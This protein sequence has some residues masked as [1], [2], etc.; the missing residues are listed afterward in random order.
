[1]GVCFSFAFA[2]VDAS[3]NVDKV[4]IE[5]EVLYKKNCSICH[6][7]KGK[8]G[9]GG[10]ANLSKSTMDVSEAVTIITEG[11]GAMTPFSEI[12]SNK[13]IKAL[14]KYIQTLKK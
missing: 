12:L 2:N 10:A 7:R 6:G 3:A 4:K 9:I 13:E 8:L 11:K 5:P 14:A 1:M